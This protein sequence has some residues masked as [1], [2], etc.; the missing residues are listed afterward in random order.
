MTQ[1]QHILTMEDR[2][3]LSLSGIEEVVSFS[4][5]QI[6]LR[7]IMGDMVIRGNELTM[8]RLDTDSK[9]LDINGEIGLIQYT[10]IK[11][12]GSLLEGLFR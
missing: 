6:E 11:K 5:A 2:K 9:K 1:E 3:K 4:G 10:D 8:S 12:K 7:T